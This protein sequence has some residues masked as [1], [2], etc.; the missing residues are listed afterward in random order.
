MRKRT[1]GRDRKHD[2][3]TARGHHRVS[4]ARTATGGIPADPQSAR[5][6]AAAATKIQGTI[7]AKTKTRQQQ[8]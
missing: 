1:G 2:G 4:A 8:W 3:T 6:G 7:H 5:D